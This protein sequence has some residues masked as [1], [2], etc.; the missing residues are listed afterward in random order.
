MEAGDRF[1]MPPGLVRCQGPHLTVLKIL[2][3][4][5]LVQTL[6]DWDRPPDPWD[7]TP[8]PK[9]VEVVDGGIRQ[10]KPICEGRDRVLYRGPLYDATLVNTSFSSTK[11]DR[12][13]IICPVKGRARIQSAGAAQES[14]RLH[15]GQAVL[16][17]AGLA[18]WTVESG[19]LV[20]Y[21]RIRLA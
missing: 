21:L 1:V 6:F 13:S 18:R 2:P 20:S 9:P 10:L 3:T 12:L 8:P 14:V 7:F 16:I 5:S 19:T 11:G 4:G 15:P 17:P